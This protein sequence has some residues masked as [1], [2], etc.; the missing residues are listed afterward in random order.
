MTGQ[1]GSACWQY[2]FRVARSM[3]VPRQT[4]ALIATILI[5]LTPAAALAAGGQTGALSRL[6]PTAPSWL[7]SGNGQAPAASSTTTNPPAGTPAR[8]TL[9]PNGL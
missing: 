6:S 9:P 1:P 8:G 3:G 4:A 5:L 2:L 7:A